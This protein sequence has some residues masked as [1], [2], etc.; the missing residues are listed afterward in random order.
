MRKRHR[1]RRHLVQGFLDSCR[2]T[3]DWF[4]IGALGPN[5][6]GKIGLSSRA[7]QSRQDPPIQSEFCLQDEFIRRRFNLCHAARGGEISIAI[8][9]P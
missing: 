1:I 9:Q 6:F 3:G 7:P 8:K 5:Q 2:H 4:E